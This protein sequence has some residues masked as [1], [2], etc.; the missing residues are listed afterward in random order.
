[1][2]IKKT[3]LI[4]C[5]ILVIAVMGA[6][7]I[8]NYAELHAELTTTFD[9]YLLDMADTSGKICSILYTNHNGEISPIQYTQYFQ[10][11]KINQ[12]PSSYTYVV[13]ADTSNMVYHPTKEKIGQP[14]SNKIILNVCDQIQSGKTDFKAKDCVSYV[15]KGEQKKAAYTVVANNHLIV[16]ATADASD[17]AGIIK[18]V[19]IKNLVI[20]TVAAIICLVISSIILIRLLQPLKNV[21]DTIVRLSEYDLSTGKEQIAHIGQSKGEIGTTAAAV[22]KLNEELTATVQMMKDRASQLQNVSRLL[23]NSSAETQSSIN[24]IDSACEEIAQ[25]ATSQAQETEQ[26][27]S[28]IADI[29]THIDDSRNIVRD[30][31]VNSNKVRIAADDAQKQMDILQESNQHVTA[32]TAKIRSAVKETGESAEQIQHAAGLITEIAEQTTLLS[33]NA[34]IEAARAGESGKG[35]AVVAQEIQKLA[36]Q[37]AESVAEID[38]IIETLAKNSTESE[39]AIIQAS[40]II[41]DQ[42]EKLHAAGEGFKAALNELDFSFKMIEQVYDIT[43]S[44]EDR[45]NAVMDSVQNLTAIAQENAASTEETSASVTAARSI[46]DKMKECADNIA[47]NANDLMDDTKKW[48]L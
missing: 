24:G 22:H 37:T 43:K 18:S 33:L 17:I 7:T 39:T 31:R 27:V 6:S 25:G 10:G 3:V 32:I 9:D 45:K 15:F 11:L 30:L 40:D 35:F 26:A 36:E 8:T 38:A 2:S 19:T 13:D 42:S 23:G 41:N 28:K 44:L 34:S 47:G 16:V 14:V 12:L 20:A 29:G 46:V 1:M 5:T 4:M 48:I 21:T